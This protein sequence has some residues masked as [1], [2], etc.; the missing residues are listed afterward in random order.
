MPLHLRILRTSD[1]AYLCKVQGIH[2][3]FQKYFTAGWEGKSEE[4]AHVYFFNR[5]ASV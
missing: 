3:D 4:Y 2:V 5:L 1:K